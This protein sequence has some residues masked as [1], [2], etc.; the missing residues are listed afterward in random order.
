MAEVVVC[1]SRTGRP[2][3]AHFQTIVAMVEGIAF[4]IYRLNLFAAKNLLERVSDGSSAGAER[5]CHGC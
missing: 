4:D 2:S 3:L 1:P 5:G